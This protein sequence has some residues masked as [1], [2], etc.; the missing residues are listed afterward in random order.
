MFGYFN[1][2]ELTAA[3]NDKISAYRQEALWEGQIP[4]QSFRHLIAQQL[5]AWAEALEPTQ[6]FSARNRQLRKA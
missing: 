2:Y 5:R 3:I 6:G 1:Q 4:R